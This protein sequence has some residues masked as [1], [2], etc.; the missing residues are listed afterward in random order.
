MLNKGYKAVSIEAVED[1]IMDRILEIRDALSNGSL[2][3][4]KTPETIEDV[5][6]DMDSDF[7][8]WHR[9]VRN[10]DQQIKKFDMAFDDGDMLE[11]L[12]EQRESAQSAYETRLLELKADDEVMEQAF[13]ALR[14]HEEHEE[15]VAQKKLELAEQRAEMIREEEELF[16]IKKDLERKKDNGIFFLYLLMFMNITIWI[17]Q[18]RKMVADQM[19]KH[20]LKA[21]RLKDQWARSLAQPKDDQPALNYG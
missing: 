10:F 16:R 14:F 6:F 18:Q 7:A 1:T 4:E 2:D 9:S 17:D 15:I 13:A 3:I 11:M 21:K 19:R 12:E 8:H 5:L 20:E